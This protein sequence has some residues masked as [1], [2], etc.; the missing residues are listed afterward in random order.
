[1]LDIEILW[2][3]IKEISKPEKEQT[4]KSSTK[5]QNDL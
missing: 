3:F 2:T 5:L 1:M 4:E